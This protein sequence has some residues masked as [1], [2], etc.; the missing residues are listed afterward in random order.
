MNYYDQLSDK[1][2]S[3]RIEV[4]KLFACSTQMTMKFIMLVNVKM[5]TA[6]GVLTFISII[7]T[8]SVSSEARKIKLQHLSFFKELKFHHHAQISFNTCF[9]CSGEQSH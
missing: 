7:N 9:G 4:I 6:V 1:N 2:S 5:P 8:T 3:S